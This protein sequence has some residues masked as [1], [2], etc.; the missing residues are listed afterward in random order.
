MR[1]PH[2]QDWRKAAVLLQAAL[3]IGLP[4]L[5]VG[6]ESALRFDVPTFRLHFFGATLAVGEYFIVLIAALLFLLVVI[7]TTLVFG[8]LWCGWL[9]PQTAWM[10]IGDMVKGVLSVKGRAPAILR[11][12]G[13]AGSHL[14]MAGFAL[15]VAIDLTWYFVSPY[16]MLPRLMHGEVGRLTA[17]SVGVIAA[18][19][20]VHFEL[21]GRRFC[22]TICPYSKMQDVLLDTHSLV[23]SFDSSRKDECMGCD[24]CVKS[25]PTGLDIKDGPQVQCVGC[26]RCIDACAKVRSRKGKTSLVGYMFGTPEGRLRDALTY[27][28]MGLTLVIAL[29][30]VATAVVYSGRD[31]VAISAVRLSGTACRVAPDGGRVAPYRLEVMNRGRAEVTLTLSVEGLEGAKLVAPDNPVTVAGNDSRTMS[32][33]VKAPPG[34][35]GRE[36]VAITITASDGRGRAAEAETSFFCP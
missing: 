15:L 17:W 36:P 7:T 28:A 23:I 34:V 13:I 3:I 9:C 25:C 2:I 32:V 31:M 14:F 8:R 22:G 21:L 1:S 26:A 24:L 29:I 18:S 10:E 12:A 20:F 16:E 30:A 19:L 5:R 4:F 27:K 33:F 6:G 11:Y 35:T